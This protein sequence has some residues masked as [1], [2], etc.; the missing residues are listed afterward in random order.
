ML[1][2]V[3]FT[4]FN[5]SYNS[6]NVSYSNL[7]NYREI[8]EEYPLKNLASEIDSY[9][10]DKEYSVF[11]FRLCFVIILFG[12][13]NYSY[14]VHPTNHFQPYIVDPLI[15]LG[16]V[17]DDE[18]VKIFESEPDVIICNT[19]AID[20]GGNVIFYDPANYGDKIIEGADSICKVSEYNDKYFQ[21]DTKSFREN[22]FLT[23]YYDPYKDMNVYI[24]IS[25]KV[26]LE[27]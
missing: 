10:V 3:L 16:L 5:I 23:Y 6:A 13:V 9:F 20:N 15:N 18:V 27:N 2:F 1:L 12:K 25:P 4:T 19:M 26:K 7:T 8:Y 21:I 17:E 22:K 24:K 11:A 14:I